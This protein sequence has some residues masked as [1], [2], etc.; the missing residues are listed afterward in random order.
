M[1]KISIPKTFINR[2]KIHSVA[3]PNAV[4]CFVEHILGE[5][6]EKIKVHF[7]DRERKKKGQ[8]ISVPVV[9]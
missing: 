6:E 4:F 7:S 2:N 1:L 5:A 8:E 9:C 3:R